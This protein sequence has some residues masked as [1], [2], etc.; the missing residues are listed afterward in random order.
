MEEDIRLWRQGEKVQRR[1]NGN[2]MS[3]KFSGWSKLGFGRVIF[4]ANVWG[5][6]WEHCMYMLLWP[7]S[8]HPALARYLFKVPFFFFSGE[9]IAV[10]E[11][12]KH[13]GFYG[14][15][16]QCLLKFSRQVLSCLLEQMLE[17]AVQGK[18]QIKNSQS[19]ELIHF[20]TG[21]QMIVINSVFTTPVGE[22]LTLLSC[23]SR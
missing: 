3:T 5:W 15:C 21:L 12:T 11:V 14:G 22:E 13:R 23:G 20:T 2:C 18:E 1:K 7:S 16:I 8:A 9:N 4:S 6:I 19:A 17:V 10:N